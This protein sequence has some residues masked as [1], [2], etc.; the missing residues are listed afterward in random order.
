MAQCLSKGVGLGLRKV[1]SLT[2]REGKIAEKQVNN[3]AV[4]RVAASRQ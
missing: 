4:R 2:F 1:M 3:S